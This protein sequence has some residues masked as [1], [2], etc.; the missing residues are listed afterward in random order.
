MYIILIDR[1]QTLNGV[2]YLLFII[3]IYMFNNDYN[4]SKHDIFLIDYNII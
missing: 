2:N 4:Q 1:N 3:L